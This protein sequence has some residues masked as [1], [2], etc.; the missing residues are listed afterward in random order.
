MFTVSI[1]IMVVGLLGVLVA[2]KLRQQPVAVLSAIIMLVG[3]GMYAWYT[4]NPPPNTDYIVFDKAVCSK[5]A[6]ALKGA[7]YSQAYWLTSEGA[8]EYTQNRIANFKEDFGG[9]VEVLAPKTSADGMIAE[10]DNNQ[11]KELTKTIPADAIIIID[12]N[13]LDGGKM[14]FLKSSYK[15]PKVFF[16]ASGSI[17]GAKKKAVITAFEKEN[18]VGMIIYKSSTDDNFVPDEDNL[19]EAFDAR[20]TLVDKN[21]VKAN[22]SNLPF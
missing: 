2:A 20:Y 3:L 6:Q 11:F 12:M 17:M 22:E 13:L 14:E 10:M 4:F 16:S 15:G 8:S 21:N 5:M 7:G 1:I 19:D 9:S 18:I